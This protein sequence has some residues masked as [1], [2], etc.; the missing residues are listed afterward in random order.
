MLTTTTSKYCYDRFM[1]KVMYPH[2]VYVL[3]SV[4][5]VFKPFLVDLSTFEFKYSNL[6][7]NF[8]INC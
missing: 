2:Y 1:R 3:I 6:L 4:S 8:N 5:V 7:L